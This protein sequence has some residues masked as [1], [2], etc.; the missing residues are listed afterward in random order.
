MLVQVT[1][2]DAREYL[3]L[4]GS[5]R[6]RLGWFGGR[7]QQC[8]YHHPLLGDGTATAG[9]ALVDVPRPLVQLARA[10]KLGEDQ[11]RLP[12]LVRRGAAAAGEPRA[13]ALPTHGLVFQQNHLIARD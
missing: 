6:Q 12:R 3:R 13:P 4:F 2:V 1:F 8:R 10:V 5:T 11:R 9:V 7:W